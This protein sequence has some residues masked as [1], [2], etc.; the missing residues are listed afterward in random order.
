MINDLKLTLS[1]SSNTSIA[2]C[3]IP[4]CPSPKLI[5]NACFPAHR[6]PMSVESVKS[7]HDELLQGI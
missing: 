4:T 6:A 3:C 2:V 5:A 7:H 1:R